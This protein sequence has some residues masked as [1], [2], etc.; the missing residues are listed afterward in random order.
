MIPHDSM[1]IT[2]IQLVDRI[3]LP[4]QPDLRR[5][6]RQ[7]CT[8]I[9]C[10]ASA[11]VIMIVRHLHKANELLSVLT[12]PTVEMASLRNLLSEQGE[13]PHTSIDPE[14]HW[15]RIWLARSR[16]RLETAGRLRRGCRVVSHRSSVDSRQCRRESAC[17]RRTSPGIRR[18]PL[19]LGRSPLQHACAA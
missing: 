1:L 18:G 12:Q 7:W 19:R 3:P 13:R 4:S 15:T 10:F 9:V 16:L 11:L 6:G 14:A 8:P 5:R 2:M 17:S